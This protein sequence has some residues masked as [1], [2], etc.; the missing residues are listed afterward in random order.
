M[1]CRR[2]R[3]LRGQGP[4]TILVVFLS[5]ACVSA[6]LTVAPARA[7]EPQ[8]SVADADSAS[9]YVAALEIA[10]A[11]GHAVTVESSLTAT[12]SVAVLP[13]D[14][15][16]L[17][18]SSSPVRVQ[19]DGDW[20]D[21]DTTL[22]ATPDGMLAPA[23]TVAPVQFSGGGSGPLARV[24]TDSEEWITL[25]SPAGDLPD[26]VV[27][28]SSAT[29]PEVFPG[30]DLRL[31]ATEFGMSEVLIIHDAQAAANPAL[32]RV[33]F[34]VAGAEL[35]EGAAD[36][37]ATAA[38]SDGSVLVSPTPTWWDSSQGGTADGPG[39]TALTQPVEATVTSSAVELNARDAALSAGVD[40]PVFVDPDWT[41]GETAWTFVDKR[42]PDA[43]Y[44]LGSNHGTDN[45][46]HVGY[47]DAVN[48]YCPDG[49]HL[50]RSFWQFDTS[51]LAG[52]HIID[53]RFNAT[54]IYSAACATD[55]FDLDLV[56]AVTSATTWNN[57]PP[58][59]WTA[60]TTAVSGW[61]SGCAQ[62][63]AVGW[64]ATAIAE[65][66]ANNNRSVA[67]VRLKADNETDWTTWRRF[68]HDT[69]MTV[70]YNSYPNAPYNTYTNEKT[71]ATTAPGPAFRNTSTE[72]V[73]LR[74]YSTDP[75]PA[76][77]LETQFRVATATGTNVL[78]STAYP[79]GYIGVG[80]QAE[81][82]VR[83]TIPAT[84]GNGSYRWNAVAHDGTD[85]SQTASTNCYFRIDNTDPVPP[86]VTTQ[87]AQPVRV[88]QQIDVSVDPGVAG[89]D[90]AGYAWSWDPGIN[91]P[92]YSGF[93]G[94]GA[95]F[96][97]GSTHWECGS[98]VELEAAPP[99]AS[100]AD[101]TVWA[102]DAAGNISG[103]A[104][105]TVST[106]AVDKTTLAA[107]AHQW[108][109]NPG[110]AAGSSG[111]PQ[112]P[113]GVGT[114]CVPDNNAPDPAAQ[115]LGQFPMALA[116]GVTWDEMGAI[117]V[118]GG[119]AGV[120]HFDAASTAPT[121]T[122][123][124]VVVDT[125]QSFAVAAWLTPTEDVA[126]AETAVSA[127]GSTYSGFTLGVN[128]NN[129]WQF[130]VHEPSSSAGS[131][132]ASSG[133]LT[134]GQPVFV[135]GVWDAGSH[136]IRLYLNGSGSPAGVTRYRPNTSTSVTAAN[137]ITLGSAWANGTVTERWTGQIG[138]PVVV[139]GV[140]SASQM[141]E[142]MLSAF[143]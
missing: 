134:H 105:L 30:V 25:E 1:R 104:T 101:L 3:Y 117:D 59:V 97:A 124:G 77:N 44:W 128:A 35:Q 129:Q 99:T 15:R 2:N 45:E 17:T 36:A 54:Q 132:V 22:H 86:Q 139:Q 53:A 136:E 51:G 49:A 85:L 78:S 126:G 69:T 63:S 109:T 48:C 19:T 93:P 18:L 110:P 91:K 71:C 80:P 102:F 10:Q 47:I 38:A 39:G 79:K 87:A 125:T 135:V 9:D 12:T 6:G 74:A 16:E 120:L 42:Y 55:N 70:Q 29:Y 46:A 41:R 130:G 114:V 32:E 34:A 94:C 100:S 27:E 142:L 107:A 28:G 92:T 68:D 111:A 13:D 4:R 67:T 113:A 64:D 40:Y 133:A 31:A 65:W 138:N 96:G 90:V 26:P 14:T 11:Y 33:E 103:P 5:L 52:T 75:D 50:D 106:L 7:E 72:R 37:S 58:Y 98:S 112:C 88:G 8:S 66:A 118:N 81:G 84:L 73:T 83:A 137:G 123:P 119:V 143:F 127:K 57:Q 89:D 116:S 108:T 61:R 76:E 24:Q 82:T 115:P 43:S 20:R 60:S 141:Y 122:D 56:G 131:A 62:E 121:T 140:P 21:I 95:D 23:A